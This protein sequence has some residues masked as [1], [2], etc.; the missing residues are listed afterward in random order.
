MFKFL[1]LSSKDFSKIERYSVSQHVPTVLAHI[2]AILGRCLD[3]VS[4]AWLVVVMPIGK[5]QQCVR[6]ISSKQAFDI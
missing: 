6:M 5:T 1:D 4:K 2:D 3:W